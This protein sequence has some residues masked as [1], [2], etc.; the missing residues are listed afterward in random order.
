ML[1]SIKCHSKRIFDWQLANPT[2]K[3]RY[4]KEEWTDSYIV[5]KA[6]WERAGYKVWKGRK[7]YLRSS[8]KI[9]FKFWK[10][11]SSFEI[12]API[13]QIALWRWRERTYIQR[14]NH[15]LRFPAVNPWYIFQI[16]RVLGPNGTFFK[17]IVTSNHFLKFMFKLVF[18]VPRKHHVI[19]KKIHHFN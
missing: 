5:P 11:S 8:R 14:P 6:T 16:E 12:L 18:L 15:I 7:A 19:L 13:C 3:S 10:G 4:S 17:Q 1:E 2:T 9:D